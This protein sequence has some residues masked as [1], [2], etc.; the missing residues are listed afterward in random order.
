M[1]NHNDLLYAGFIHD[2]EKEFA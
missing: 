2:A 1:R